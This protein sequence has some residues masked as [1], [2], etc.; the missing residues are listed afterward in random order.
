MFQNYT[1]RQNST[2]LSANG[3]NNGHFCYLTSSS[4]T[5]WVR[6]VGISK[7]NE[8]QELCKDMEAIWKAEPSSL[9]YS[10]SIAYLALLWELGGTGRFTG[11][12]L[13]TLC[14]PLS[15]G[16]KTHSPA[17]L[18]NIPFTD[19]LLGI[20]VEKIRHH[21]C[22]CPLGVQKQRLVLQIKWCSSVQMDFHS[23]FLLR[24]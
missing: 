22:T 8:L 9:P 21:Q 18:C 1:F 20:S 15:V 13:H 16:D 7:K 6:C 17:W 14:A 5:K 3:L 10:L 23:S 11:W 12:G 4:L 2:W 24:I 19:P